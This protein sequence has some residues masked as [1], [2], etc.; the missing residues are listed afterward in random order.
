VQ[1]LIGVREQVERAGRNLIRDEMPEQH[2]ALFQALPMLV[3]GSV[4]RAGRPWASILASEPGFI[5]APDSKTLRVTAVPLLG[6]P[7]ADNLRVG[8]PLGLLGIQLETRR[9]N[10]A[11]GR[12]TMQGAHSFTVGVEQS[13]GNCKQYIQARAPTFVPE[14]RRA[15]GSVTLEGSQLSARASP[16]LVA[17][18]ATGIASA[19]EARV[20][21]LLLTF[22]L[23]SIPTAAIVPT[24]ALV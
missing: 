20:R 13:F 10:R 14:L 22:A 17:G 4:D 15:A 6:D 5:W 24:E 16:L 19:P 18:F 12:I 3:V 9:R 21:T 23:G 2:R 7:L 11:N 1:S 8:A